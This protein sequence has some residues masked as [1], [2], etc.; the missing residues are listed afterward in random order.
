MITVPGAASRSYTSV[1]HHNREWLR[2][3]AAAPFL[4]RTIIY[5]GENKK[6]GT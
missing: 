1:D 4:G 3:V 2:H 6:E 5:T